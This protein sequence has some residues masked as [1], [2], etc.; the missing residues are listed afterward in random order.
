MLGSLNKPI[1]QNKSKEAHV[2]GAGGSEGGVGRFFIGLTMMVGGGYLFFSS[3]HVTHQFSF[4]H[5]I[6][7][8]GGFSVT[9]GLVLVPFVFGIGLIFY[10]SKNILGWILAAS[11]LVMLGFGVL[12]RINFR[13]ER[14][15]AFSLMMILVLFIGG[16]GLMLS[17]LRK[18]D[19]K[20]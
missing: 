15:S 7:R 11:S 3:I 18:L 20:Y 13:F 12:A 6:F 5:S 17:S 9:S 2:R 1:S 14:M 19:S 8:V 16:L 4:G 10:N